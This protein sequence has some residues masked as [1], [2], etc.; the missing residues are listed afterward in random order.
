MRLYDI[1][2]EVRMN[3]WDGIWECDFYS[4]PELRKK[5]ASYKVDLFQD[6]I[7]IDSDTIC[8]DVG[9]GGGYVSK[10]LYKRF[11]CTIFSCDSST[12]AINYAIEKNSFEKCNYIVSC[13]Q[14]INLPCEVADVVL[15]IG[16]LEHISNID[17]ALSEIRRILKKNGKLVIIS[18][19]RYS[20]IF[21][22][23]I[24]KQLLGKWKYGY[25]KNWSPLKL[26][27]KLIEHGF[28]ITETSIHQGFGDFN[29]LNR[30]DK[31]ISR[32]STYWGRYIQIIG[33]KYD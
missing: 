7:N 26:E 24:I 1:S 30:I 5:K 29:K 33:G 15:C 11:N 10:E 12:S 4:V 18:S 28:F 6:A 17:S 27:K 9:C 25:Q 13:A 16:V 19:N 8:V 2:L 22:H 23:R 14:D 20:V 31:I 32:L 3:I 21:I